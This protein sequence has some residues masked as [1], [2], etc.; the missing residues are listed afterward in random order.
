M[1]VVLWTKWF[2]Y[3]HVLF[4][5]LLT[6]RKKIHKDAVKIPQV[7]EHYNVFLINSIALIDIQLTQLHENIH[8][9]TSLFDN[10]KI[11]W[12]FCAIRIEFTYENEFSL[13]RSKQLLFQSTTHALM[14]LR[15]SQI[16]IPSLMTLSMFFFHSLRTF[17][18]AHLMIFIYEKERK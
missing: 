3:R 17:C 16:K 2:H 5:N 11:K 9:K 13:S 4:L 7:M 1:I 14:L 10:L 15:I 8:E 6:E 18:C 12:F